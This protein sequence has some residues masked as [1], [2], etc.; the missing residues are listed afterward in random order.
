MSGKR[1]SRYAPI[2]RRRSRQQVLAW[3]PHVLRAI[4][5]PATRGGSKRS[6]SFSL[7]T[8]RQIIG[9]GVNRLLLYGS[10]ASA[11]LRVPARLGDRIK[12]AAALVNQF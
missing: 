6:F 8:F 3:F 5:A 4:A 11:P 12:C 7:Q 10:R 1:F 2:Y 9:V